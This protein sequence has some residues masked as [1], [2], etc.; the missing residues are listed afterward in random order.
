MDKNQMPCDLQ[1]TSADISVGHT[2]I[3]HDLSL[4]FPRGQ[5]TVLLGPNGCGKTSLLQCL[6]G[7]SS[8]SSGS[9]TYQ[10]ESLIDM[11][12]RKRARKIAFLPQVRS[13]IP[14]I[15]VHTLVEHG[16]FPY[17]GFSRR[18]NAEDRRLVDQAM[19]ACGV[20]SYADR[21]VDTLSGG[22]RQRVFLAMVLAQATPL[23]VLDEP[24]TYLDPKSQNEIMDLVTSLRDRGKT[25]I[26]VL[27]DLA[28][29]ARTADYLVIMSDAR[30]VIASGPKEEV[31]NTSAISDVFGVSMHRVSIDGGWHYLFF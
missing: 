22:M 27:H 5:I 17:L 25:V 3:L 13:I 8:V 10:G 19:K 28:Q 30:R 24:T 4:S 16:R 18:P 15:P 20:L 29:A 14:S 21:S 1:F 26:M 9:L 31:L 12:E 7:M 6:N 2:P 23:I 11:P